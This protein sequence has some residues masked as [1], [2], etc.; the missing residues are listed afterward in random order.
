MRTKRSFPRAH[1]FSL[2]ECLVY[3]AV[4]AVV[5]AVAFSMFYQY[6][7]HSRRLQVMAADV[8]Q[9]MKAGEQWR[10]DLR[11][12]VGP[13]QLETNAQEQALQVPQA[14]G[15]ITYLFS[16]GSI[17]RIEN[18]PA[19]PR[20]LVPHVKASR[21]VADPRQVV[22]AWKWELELQPSSRKAK[23]RPLF[24]FLVAVPKEVVP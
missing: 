7:S 12:A 20:L 22:S 9:V 18:E 2:L 5:T 19:D 3:I 14:R 23:L 17:W 8:L 10:Q 11:Q 15:K 1:G 16:L 13:L 21:M 6:L 24:T 4:F